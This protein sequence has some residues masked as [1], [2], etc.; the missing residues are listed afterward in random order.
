MAELTPDIARDDET[1]DVSCLSYFSSFNRQSFETGNT[2]QPAGQPDGTTATELPS[3]LRGDGKVPHPP[4][5]STI[6]PIAIAIPA[7]DVSQQPASRRRSKRGGARNRK[8]EGSSPS[9]TPTALGSTPSAPSPSQPS[10]QTPPVI[11]PANPIAQL[12]HQH[13]QS[14]ATQ[15][16]TT[17]STGTPIPTILLQ[18]LLVNL[19]PEQQQ[20]AAQLQDQFFRLITNIGQNSPS[21]LSIIAPNPAALQ[22]QGPS[23]ANDPATYQTVPLHPAQA[24]PMNCPTAAP[25]MPGNFALNGGAAQGHFHAPQAYVQTSPFPFQVS[26]PAA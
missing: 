20:V 18:P 7:G 11:S 5:R 25:A 10:S 13:N 19:T 14:V 4:M 26:P 22:Q 1:D 16:R 2:E 12:V 3:E 9:Q 23:A 8:S 17:Q 21:P 15:L 6:T 24:P